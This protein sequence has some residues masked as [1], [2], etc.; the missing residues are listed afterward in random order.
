MRILLLISVIIITA[1]EGIF[2]QRIITPKDETGFIT[3]FRDGREIG[4]RYE[5]G[6]MVG[7]SNKFISNDYGKFYQI[8]I[9][10]QNLS[11]E[12]VTFHPESIIARI[13]NNSEEEKTL[14]VYSA[15]EFQR[16]VNREDFWTMVA[17]SINVAA[18]NYQAPGNYN[19]IIMMDKLMS[20]DNKLTDIDNRIRNQGY[21]KANTIHHGEGI[22]GVMNVKRK[23]G[24]EMIVILPINNHNY[25]FR[26]DL[27]KEKKRKTE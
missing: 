6:F 24:K 3:E 16:K 4:M 8:G 13:I 23:R 10:I 25:V 15:D 26:W 22:Y 21:L 2:A 11:G 18:S 19:Q 27:S 20:I 14:K 5:N 7:M 1:S 9:Y 12:S 17:A